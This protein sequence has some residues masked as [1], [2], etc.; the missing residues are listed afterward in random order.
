MKIPLPKMMR[1]WREREFAAKLAP[2][3]VRTG[4]RLWAFLARRP[5]LYHA[6]CEGAS[7]ALGW[8]G[9]ARG[10]FRALPLAAGWT[11]VRDM[12]APEGR[13]FHSLWAE[14]QRREARR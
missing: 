1:H 3:T 8:A 12:P 5:M 9:R 13:S 10:R 7:R 6:L 14:R 11:Q 2:R 4:L